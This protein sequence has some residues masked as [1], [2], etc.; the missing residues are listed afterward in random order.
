MRI[1]RIVLAASAAALA[2]GVQ[3]QQQQAQGQIATYN[4][5]FSACMEGRGYTIK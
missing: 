3:A 4:R 1:A 2:W 5:A